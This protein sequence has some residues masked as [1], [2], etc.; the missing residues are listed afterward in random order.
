[1]TPTSYYS[2]NDTEFDINDIPTNAVVVIFTSCQGTWPTKGLGAFLQ[3]YFPAAY[4]Q[5]RT[6][7]S[8]YLD[9]NGLLTNAL[10]G[11]CHLIHP[12]PNDYL[13]SGVPF[14]YI[15]CLFS[16]TGDSHRNWLGKK[17]GRDR[18]A[19]VLAQT[20]SAFAQLKEI[21][22]GNGLHTAA[23]AASHSAGE[24]NAYGIVPTTYTY[25]TASGGN[26]KVFVGQENGKSFQLERKDVKELIGKH[27]QGWVGVF[28]TLKKRT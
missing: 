2:G 22:T 14:I 20:D 4:E 3:Q 18:K 21:L 17:K 28:R 26:T 11:S 7:C 8:Q 10:V 1:M 19:K 16:S 25:Q 27:F 6:H 13:N 23:A 5:Y 24:R 15:A 9:D 12:Q